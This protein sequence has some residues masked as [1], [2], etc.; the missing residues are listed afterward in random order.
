MI[1]NQWHAIAIAAE[2]KSGR[3]AG[4]I[5]MGQKPLDAVSAGIDPARAEAWLGR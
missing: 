5:R 3:A 2:V 4:V 1:P